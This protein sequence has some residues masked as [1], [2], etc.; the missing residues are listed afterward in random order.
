MSCTVSS[1][2]C[3]LGALG[4]A[5]RELLDRIE[6]ILDAFERQQRPQQPR[7]ASSRPPIDVTVRSIS[8]SSDPVRPPIADSMTLRFLSVVGSMIRQSRRSG[9]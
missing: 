8:C 9:T 3:T 7:H 2:S 1:V 5:E 6:P 4:G